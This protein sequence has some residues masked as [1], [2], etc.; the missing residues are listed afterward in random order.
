[1]RKT[2]TLALFAA[3]VLPFFA[4]CGGSPAGKLV[5]HMDKV[6]GLLESNADDAAKA[7]EA[8]KGYMADHS[9][10]I[11][12]L[13]A[14]VATKMLEVQ[15]ELKEKMEKASSLEEKAA[16]AQ[17]AASKM[18]IDESTVTKAKEAEARMKKVIAD[19]PNLAENEE[20]MAQLDS[21]KGMMK[22][23]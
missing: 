22:G 2:L 5:D 15:K 19:H 14:E 21:L 4:A 8:L 11:Q 13:Q 17:E 20:L 6:A 12:A 7:N 3:L 9:A 1:M 16:I 23:R 18:G 10:E